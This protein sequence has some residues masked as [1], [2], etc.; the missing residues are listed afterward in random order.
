MRKVLLGLALGFAL[1]G[2]AWAIQDFSPPWV[3][4][5]K[6]P[7]W[8]GGST[9]SEAWEFWGNPLGTT[10]PAHWDN[11]FGPPAGFNP[12]N[13]SPQFISNG[14]GLT[15]VN[16]WHVDVDGGGF[17]VFIPNDPQD[18]PNKM[19]H[20]QYTSDKSSLQPPQS[21][22]PGV[23][24]AGGVAGH[25]PSDGGDN[26]YTYEWTITLHPNPAS[27]TIFVQFPASTNIGEVDV[28]TICYT[29]EPTT[30]AL[31]AFGGLAMVRRGRK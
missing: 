1:V 9:T 17:S 5:P 27:E 12:I 23:T 22:P 10:A 19:I 21:N 26:W 2:P 6:N 3:V 24:H 20:L 18:R 8:A 4:D 29:P 30:L 13:A 28:A 7:Q 14:P 31:L 11:P 16:T 15:G 25:G